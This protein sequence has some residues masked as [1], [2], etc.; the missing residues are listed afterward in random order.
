[1]GLGEQIVAHFQKPA[2]LGTI[3]NKSMSFPS[4]PSIHSP[5]GASLHLKAGRAREEIAAEQIKLSK[6]R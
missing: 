5:S 1:M 3:A 6:S 2:R 4:D